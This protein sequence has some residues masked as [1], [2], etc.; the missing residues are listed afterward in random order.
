MIGE[1]CR[2]ESHKHDPTGN[3]FLH[4]TA[5]IGCKKLQETIS[6]SGLVIKVRVWSVEIYREGFSEDRVCILMYD[7]LGRRLA[8]LG[9][10]FR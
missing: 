3:N 9:D 8:Y 2:Q 7:F 5:I 4:A 1:C 10:K 6:A